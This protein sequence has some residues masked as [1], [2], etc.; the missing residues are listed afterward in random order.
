MKVH[1]AELA[2]VEGEISRLEAEISQLQN[3]LKHEQQVT[4]ESQSKQWQHG[5][6]LQYPSVLTTNPAPINKGGNE[7]MAYETKALHFI[8]KAI[9]GDYNL[10][11]FGSTVADRKLGNSRGFDDQKE[12]HVREAA[13]FQD[14]VPRKSGMLKPSSP[15]RDP[16][17][18][19]PKVRTD[20][21]SAH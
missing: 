5:T 3:S 15:L 7:M 16:R 12:N 14:K 11:D 21:S 9:K 18:P 4:K 6:L 2:M 13:I 8:S 19:S 20:N 10:N 17:H 1:L